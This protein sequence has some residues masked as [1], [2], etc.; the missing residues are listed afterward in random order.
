MK[1][2]YERTGGFGGMRIALDLDLHT[3]PDDEALALED[4]VKEADFFHLDQSFDQGMLADGFQYAITI[5]GGRKK[6][7]IR[8]SESSVPDVLRP[9]LDELLMRARSQRR[10]G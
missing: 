3:L 1:I 4:M 8:F 2:N 6:R 7:T 10:I 9:L 5:D